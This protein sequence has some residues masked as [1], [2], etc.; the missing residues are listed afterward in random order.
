L[1]AT[2]IDVADQRAARLGPFTAMG[3]AGLTTS[4]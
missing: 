4:F 3:A 2:A 1:P